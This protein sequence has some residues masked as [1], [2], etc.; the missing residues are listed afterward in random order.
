M[1]SEQLSHGNPEEIERELFEAI[2]VEK[3]DIVF[4]QIEEEQYAAVLEVKRIPSERIRKYGF[5]F[6]GKRVL[7]G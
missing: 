1:A 6:E 7:I 5:A 2:H 4:P 3:P